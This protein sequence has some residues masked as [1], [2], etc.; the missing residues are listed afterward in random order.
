MRGAIIR[1]EKTHSSAMRC[2]LAR[3][4]G[5]SRLDGPLQAKDACGNRKASDRAAEGS[6]APLAR[7]E[8]ARALNSTPRGSRRTLC[9]CIPRRPSHESDYQISGSPGFVIEAMRKIESHFI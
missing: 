7:S 3:S 5:A 2:L 6:A 4:A 8:L 9:G 1:L